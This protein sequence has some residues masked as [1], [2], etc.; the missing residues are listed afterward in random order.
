MFSVIPSKALGTRKILLTATLTKSATTR[1]SSS[2]LSSLLDNFTSTS[3]KSNDTEKPL[4][5]ITGLDGYVGPWTA[6]SFLKDG[7]FRVRG[8]VRQNP[9]QNKMNAIQEAF[10]SEGLYENLEIVEAELLDPDSIDDAITRSNFVVHL[11]SPYYLNNVT[12]EELMKPAIEGTLSTLESCAR[13]NVQRC[14]FT[15]SYACIRW[16]SNPPKV[17]DESTWSELNLLGDYPASK[18]QAEKAGWEFFANQGRRSP[19]QLEIATICPTMITGPAIGNPNVVSEEFMT[20]LLYNQKTNIKLASNYYADV[21]DVA[22]AHYQAI[23]V[24]EAAN[25]RFLVHGSKPYTLDDFCKVIS[26]YY[27]NY[28]FPKGHDGMDGSAANGIINDNSAS[29]NVLK[30]EYIPFEQTVVDM[31]DSLMKSGRIQDF[32]NKLAQQQSQSHEEKLIVA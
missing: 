12:R 6:L 25:K 26:E 7:N 20:S 14:V 5:T 28:K 24:P 30:M 15:S 32:E 22:K 9:C 8:T 18:L 4:V 1:A 21:R 13:H 3:S 11:A 29:K 16:T 10:E 27:P 31:I 23:K 17:F 19:Q 2:Y